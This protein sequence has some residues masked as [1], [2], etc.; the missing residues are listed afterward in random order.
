MVYWCLG[1]SDE[2]KEGKWVWFTEELSTR[3]SNWKYN[4]PDNGPHV[5]GA[6]YAVMDVAKAGNTSALNR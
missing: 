2:A 5:Y 6:D 3:Y 4:E 1:I